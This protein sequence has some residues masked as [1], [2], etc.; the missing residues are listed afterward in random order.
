MESIWKA[1]VVWGF[2]APFQTRPLNFMQLSLFNLNPPSLGLHNDSPFPPL[3]WVTIHHHDTNITRGGH[4]PREGVWGC[5]AVMTPFFQTSR[6]SLAYQFTIIAPLLGWK[7]KSCLVVLHRLP[8]IFKNWKTVFTVQKY[9]A[10]NFQNSKKSFFFL[11][12][13]WSFKNIF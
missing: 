8:L 2:F 10:P 7:K 5:A 9:T 3:L 6:R 12:E 13:F 4:W 1:K 11:W